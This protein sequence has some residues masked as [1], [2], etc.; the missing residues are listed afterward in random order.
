MKKVFYLCALSF[1]ACL[2]A[3]AQVDKEI[4]QK[5]IVYPAPIREPEKPKNEAPNQI[6]TVVQEPPSFPGGQEAMA[7]FLRQNFQYPKK[8]KKL[9][10]TGKVYVRFVVNKTGE[11]TD[12]TTLKGI[13]NCPECNEEAIRLVKMMP[14]WEPAKQNGNVVSTYYNLPFT[15]AL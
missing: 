5:E 15:F 12:V 8:A 14:K 6:Y 13:E 3:Q 9:G 11:I 1:L 7:K 10:I 4:G 2:Q